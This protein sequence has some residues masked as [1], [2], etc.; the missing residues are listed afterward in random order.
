MD[1][2]DLHIAKILLKNCRTTYRLIAEELNLSLNAIYKRV[3]NLIDL[4]IIRAFTA[5]PSLIAL[6]GIEVLIY[7]KT[8]GKDTTLISQE[9]GLNNNTYFVGVAGGNLLYIGGFLKNISELHEC[10]ISMSTIGK[11]ENTLTLIKKYPYRINPE[12]LIDLD[13]K[14]LE[15][16]STDGRKTIKD[17]GDEIKISAK[18]V[19]K[20]INKMIEYDLVDFSINFAPQILTSQFH[21]Y[22]ERESD[23]NE[24]LKRIEKKYENNI[25]YLQQYSNIPN[26]IMMTALTKTNNEAAELYRQLQNEGF[27]ELSHDIFY[28]GFFFKTWRDSANI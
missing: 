4:G 25:L 7:G 18:T 3:Q 22:L 9:L 2:I 10:I 1:E 12:K 14:I 23:Y 15:D 17:I 20:H 8:I 16:I 24:E 28:K 26:L 11:L 5:R 6:N 27:K 13:Y 21:I 19:Q